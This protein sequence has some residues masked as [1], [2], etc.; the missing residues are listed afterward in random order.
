MF[1]VVARSWRERREGWIGGARVI[2]R[3]AKIFCMIL[4]CW[5]HVIIH[6]SKPTECATVSPIRNYGD[7]VSM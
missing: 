7:D 1:S 6:L 3:A 4:Y 2:F 5:V